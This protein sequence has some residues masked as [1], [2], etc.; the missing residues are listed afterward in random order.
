MIVIRNARV[1][2]PDS[3][4]NGEVRDIWVDG[5]FISAPPAT[6]CNPQV[7]DA[8]EMIL[9]PAGIE[10]HTH[11]AGAGLN[12]SRT[13]LLGKPDACAALLPS[14]GES[15]R[16]YLRMGY[17]TVFDAAMPPS[18]AYQ[19]HIDLKEM[20]CL[21]TGSYTLMGDH[22]VLLNALALGEKNTIRDVIAWLL[23]AS[24]GYAVKLVNPGSGYLWRRGRKPPE[25][26]EPLGIGKLT[27]RKI[28][29]GVM[30]AVNEMGLPHGI[31]LHAGMLGKPGS[32]KSFCNTVDALEGQRAHL[33]HIQ[34]YCYGDD[35]QGGLTS[36]AEKVVEKVGR[37]PNLTFDVGQVL[38]GPAMAISADLGALAYLQRLMGG[39]WI[40]KLHEAEG[41]TASL[42]LAYL[43][44][45]AAAAV[46][47]AVGLELMLRFPDPGRMFLTTD[48]PNGG[49][50]ANYPQV[51]SWL[52]NKAERDVVL[53]SIHPSA[54]KFTGLAGINRE[55]SISEIIAMTSS[56]PA[57]S[58]GLH[59]RGRLSPGSRADIRCFREQTNKAAMF[60]NPCWV[61]KSGRIIA[62]DGRVPSPP[63]MQQTLVVCPEWDRDRKRS[64]L[65]QLSEYIS[66]SSEHYGLGP[67][68]EEMAFKEVPCT[69]RES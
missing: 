13:L 67:R 30:E 68:R 7:I 28:I 43:Q 31:H 20:P 50:F 63:G 40:C 56:G 23:E 5:E 29:Q 58:L 69:S 35:G 54:G 19:T 33:C 18:H 25:L 15:A 17:T 12:S 57:R 45:D 42:P 2:D 24:G 47:W 8:R 11:V 26:D 38:F 10:I 32:W 37:Y 53:K 66:F 16:Q 46:Q 27:Q 65:K 62:R 64:I 55:L 36:A 51:I 61:M 60:S 34:F 49:L 1:Y 41:G 9:A 6:D 59:D 4:I 44:K 3:D 52:M 14:A 48:H 21:D 22:R 39:A